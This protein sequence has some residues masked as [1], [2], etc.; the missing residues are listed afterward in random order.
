MSLINCFKRRRKSD[1]TSGSVEGI[2]DGSSQGTSTLSYDD[3][4]GHIGRMKRTMW[5][6]GVEVME[7]E[8][9]SSKSVEAG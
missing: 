8:N 2:N 9:E 4:G 3:C 1:E 6:T 5:F 7:N